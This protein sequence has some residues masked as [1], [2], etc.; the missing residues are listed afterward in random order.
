MTVDKLKARLVAKGYHQ[1][2]GIDYFDSFF[3]VA[4][5]V[6]VCLFLAIVAAN[7]WSLHQLDI[8]NAF[9]HGHLNEEVY[10]VSPQGYTKA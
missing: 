5:M 3:P 7:S 6:T 9:S 8:N 10:M 2:E 4:K 1:I